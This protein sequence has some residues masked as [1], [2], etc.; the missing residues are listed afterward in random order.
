V[1]EV[2]DYVE[3]EVQRLTLLLFKYEQTPMSL[4]SGQSFPLS[5]TGTT[6]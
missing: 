1:R 4:L 3:R 6:P 5:R 2:A